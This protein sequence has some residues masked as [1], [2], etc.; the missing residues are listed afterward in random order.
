MGPEYYLEIAALYLKSRHPDLARI[1]AVMSRYGV[2][3]VHEKEDLIPPIQP[4][5]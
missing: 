2:V 3:P 4:E 5:R 1:G